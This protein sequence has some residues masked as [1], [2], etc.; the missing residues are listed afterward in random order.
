LFRGDTLFDERLVAAVVETPGA[1]LTAPEGDAIDAGEPV[2]AHVPHAE[3]AAAAEWLRAPTTAPAPAGVTARSPESLAPA[4]TAQLRKFDPPWVV[5]ARRGA[6]RA[7]EARLFASAYKGITDLVTNWVWPVP[8]LAATRMLAR[9]R[10]H[11]NTVTLISWGLTLAAMQAF[12]SGAFGLGLL[13][14]WGMTFLD[15]VD[16][17]LARVTLTSS[18]VGHVLDHGLDIIHPPFWYLAWGL[19]LGPGH[20]FATAVVVGGYVV[21]RLMEGVFLWAFGIETHSWRPLDSMFRTITARRNPNLILLMVGALG[22]RPD[23]G[24]VMVALWTAVS[25]GFHGV[26]MLQAFA[27][28]RRG[29]TIQ[30]WHGAVPAPPTEASGVSQDRPS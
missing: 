24:L 3:A 13:A 22:G 9:H 27:A 17:K 5:R 28:R 29:E 7:V 21:G 2:A 8:A 14:A 6:E 26:R 23:L 25:L 30:P 15:T 1:A 11:P 4:Y 20:E 16:G 18:R 12:F 19:G 10:V